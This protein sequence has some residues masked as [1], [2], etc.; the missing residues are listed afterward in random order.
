MMNVNLF[1]HLKIINITLPFMQNGGSIINV[2]SI[3]S[4]NGKGSNIGYCASK[5][6]LDSVT[7]PFSITLSKIRVNSICPGLLRQI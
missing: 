5:A 2:S 3:A 4:I 6:A 7:K 1:N